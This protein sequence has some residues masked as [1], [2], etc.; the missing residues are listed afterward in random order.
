MKKKHSPLL[1]TGIITISTAVAVL[2]LCNVLV[3]SRARTHVFD[4]IAGIPYNRVGLLIETTS[5]SDSMTTDLYREYRIRAAAD[6]YAAGKIHHVLVCGGTNIL[7]DEGRAVKQALVALGLSESH[8]TV[9]YGGNRTYDII[10]HIRTTYRL[11]TATIISD[12]FHTYRAVFIS[13]HLGIDAV[14][15]CSRTVE[16]Q[17][18][19]RHSIRE[20]FARVR[21]VADVFLHSPPFLLQRIRA[22]YIS[23][24]ISHQLP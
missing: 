10:R 4:S 23:N 20:V 18:S 16:W 13:R 8:V 3:V 7:D 14:A 24:T 19:I 22:P 11:P 12:R 15:Y 9:D 2:F 1:S 6:L 21:A 17:Y 5:Q